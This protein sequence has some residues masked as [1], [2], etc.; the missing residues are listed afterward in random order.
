[1][2]IGCY[3]TCPFDLKFNA[4]S[5]AEEKNTNESVRM[6]RILLLHFKHEWHNKWS[7]PLKMNFT[8]RKN[9]FC[10]PNDRNKNVQCY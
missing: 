10:R 5:N 8:T 4:Q 1:M 3:R 9:V 7:D 6:N 2:L